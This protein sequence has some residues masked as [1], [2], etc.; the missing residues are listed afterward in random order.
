M[1]FIDTSTSPGENTSELRR[2]AVA[3]RCRG[4]GLGRRLVNTLMEHA[5][6]TGVKNVW[7]R[8]QSANAVALTAYEKYGFK[9]D[10]E[11]VPFKNMK[12][13]VLSRDVN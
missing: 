7:L 4:H 13:H 10:G 8:T 5:R 11:Y 12:T 6:A 9:V 1:C 2:F 3:K